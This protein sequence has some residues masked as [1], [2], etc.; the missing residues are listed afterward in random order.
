VPPASVSASLPSISEATRSF[1]RWLG[2]RTRIVEADL[3]FK[4]EQMATTPFAFLRATFY[5]WVQVW[6]LRC[7][8]VAAAPHVLAVGDLHTENFGSWRDAE[9]RLV[10]GVNDFDE[11]Y[12]MA[13]T[14]DLVRLATSVRL[15][16][17][18]GRMRLTPRRACDAIANGYRAALKG[19]G[20]P[21]VLAEQHAVL[22]READNELRDPVRFWQTMDALPEEADVP[23]D[24]ARL[25]RAALPRH[26]AGRFA[27][28]RAGLGSLGHE[29]FVAIAEF[30]GGRV[31]REVK[32]LVPSACVWAAPPPGT[33]AIH[34]STIVR[35]AVRCADPFLTPRRDWVVRRL[36]PDCSRIEVMA[37]R[38]K[39]DQEPLLHAMGAETAN[40][41]LGTASSRIADVLRDLDTRPADWLRSASKEMLKAVIRDFDAWSRRSP[42]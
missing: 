8:D 16:I 3:A 34:Y 6:T 30:E 41:H 25:L 26:A 18:A 12:P 37:A 27:R 39:T 2:A 11:A 1:E 35:R 31:A 38:T 21:Y 9:G 14:N 22:R 23:D 5:R 4:H 15:S 19:G 17:L 13:Y 24:A 40:I 7:P 10:W 32:A 20:T 42:S 28:R 36:A 33:T 29:R